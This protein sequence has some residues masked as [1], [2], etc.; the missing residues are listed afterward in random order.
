MVS[1][2]KR[3]EHTRTRKVFLVLAGLLALA[4]AVGSGIAIGGIRYAESKVTTVGVGPGC[5]ENGCLPAVNPLCV[6]KACNY[7]ILGSDSRAGFTS[8]QQA[9]FGDA[10]HVTGQRSD[11]IMLVHVDLA[12]KRITVVSI[13]RDLRVNIPG[14]GFGKINTAF[15]YGPNETVRVVHGLF[16]MT[17]NHYIE[18][19]F[20]GFIQVVNALHGVPICID[21]PMI[22]TLAGLRLPRRG[23]YNLQGSQALA[24]VRARHV[25]GDAIPDFARIAR[26]QQF[27]RAAMQKLLA[28]GAFLHFTSLI[29]ALSKNFVR[30]DNLSLY[31]IKEL[32]Q[33]I[34]SVGQTNVDFRVL[35][36]VPFALG[37]VDY[38]RLV[39]PGARKFFSALRKGQSLG[40]LG[41]GLLLTP[42]SPAN[43]T[44]RI[45]DASS[46]GK[47]DAVETYLKNAGFAVLP[48]EPAPADLTKSQLL[49]G[50]TNAKPQGVVASYLPRLPVTF[51]R[52]G[53]PGASVV[54]VIGPDFR[55]IS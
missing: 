42:I 14:H 19:N 6:N 32:S 47:V 33:Q 18:I 30:D 10:H 44:I 37:G 49:Y 54:V 7:L 17:I 45:Y 53:T 52:A 40:K 12:R 9:Q 21:H 31:T 5:T 20:T 50:P 8:A 38:V 22:D 13:P 26:Q 3:R 35:P 55:G 34:G 24:F 36:A 43:I 46:G 51:T 28:P 23:C 39:Q 48:V 27:L 29:D 1:G 2:S 4:L 11:T 25:Q 16:G 15:D 41:Q